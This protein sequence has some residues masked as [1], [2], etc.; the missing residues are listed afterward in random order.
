VQRVP[1]PFAG[2]ISEEPDARQTCRLALVGLPDDSQSTYRKGPSTA[3]SRIRS[4]YNGDCYN[5]STE[6]GVDLTGSLFDAGDLLS[7]ANWQETAAAYETMTRELLAEGKVPF[8]LGGDHA[9]TVPVVAAFAEIGRPIHVIQLDAHC[10]LY[11]EY[12]GSRTSHACV[13]ARLLEMDHIASITQIGIR[14]L[15]KEQRAVSEAEAERVFIHEARHCKT[16]MPKLDYLDAESNVYVTLDLDGLDP[17]YAPGVSHPVP[18]GLTTRQVLDVLHEANWNLVGM[19]VVELNPEQ[20][21]HDLTAVLA[22]RLL[23]EGMGCA[24]R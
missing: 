24:V 17:A 11:R 19:D 10:D 22:G 20:D 4:A 18:G 6:L 15:N 8:F 3:P 16:M 23:H 7:G 13:A 5:S 14:T 1:S 12:R 2:C 21:I 9:V